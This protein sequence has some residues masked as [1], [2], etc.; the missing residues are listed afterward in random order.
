MTTRIL[1][2]LIGW[3]LSLH[4]AA[5]RYEW[6]A[7]PDG[8]GNIEP[9][10]ALTVDDAGN[11]YLAY[12]YVGAL[13]VGGAALATWPGAGGWDVAVTKFDPVGMP[14]WTTTFGSPAHEAPQD[15]GVDQDGAVYVAFDQSGASPLAAEDTSFIVPSA[16]HV[17][18][19]DA[20]GRCRRLASFNGRPR[21]DAVR[22][23]I[24]VS[25][26]QSIYRLDTALATVWSHTSSAG[27]PQFDGGAS[28]LGAVAA[29]ADRVV[30][31]GY[32]ALGGPVDIGGLTAPGNG[33]G[34]DQAV[35]VVFDT[36]GTGLWAYQTDGLNAGL[37]RPMDV[38]M[39]EAGNVFLGIW[40][41]GYPFQFA[42]ATVDNPG[43]SNQVCALLKLDAG[44]NEVWAVQFQ[45]T[46]GAN[47]YSVAVN[48]FGEAVFSG[49]VTDGGS[50]GP[51][52]MPAA[53]GM[54][55]AKVASDGTPIWLKDDF[56]AAQN[57]SAMA[58]WMDDGPSGDF[59]IGLRNYGALS[60][61]CLPIT[62]A[63]NFVVGRISDAQQV[64]PAADFSFITGA[65]DVQFTDASTDAEEW[66]WDFGDGNYS[67]DQDPLH[68]YALPGTYTVVLTAISGTCSDTDTAEVTVFNTNVLEV[69][70]ILF[71][72][73]P[74]PTDAQVTI[75][76]DGSISAVR[77]LDTSGRVVMLE[78]GAVS[79]GVRT[80][81]VSML[82]AG[83]Y[84][85]QVLTA[86]GQSARM[87]QVR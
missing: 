54:Y 71:T 10:M 35:V 61:D 33:T 15:I 51:Y 45:A 1:T 40:S 46:F 36:A 56:G 84:I 48:V 50:F 76:G 87:M 23:E 63:P 41:D 86:V 6:V 57:G 53:Q 24:Y 81:D 75:A 59:W 47:L 8:P 25:V 32:D 16:G 58:F 17:M 31:S 85:V 65:L 44:G 66:S 80:L 39:D 52:S 67:S 12:R 68:V 60:M 64:L 7:L 26:Y 14:V 18:K 70:G 34:Y 38:A 21:L 79:A 11:S 9:G 27:T 13:T 69:G 37:E 22:R 78:T 19:L 49:P 77:I 83:T 5:Q 2:I 72:L 62:T 28:Y 82:E 4:S 74:N 20:S 29:R 3:L 43:G 30:F 55:V 73:Q 42:G